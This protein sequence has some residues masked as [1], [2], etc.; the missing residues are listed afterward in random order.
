ML[1]SELPPSMFYCGEQKLYV[2]GIEEDKLTVVLEWT[3]LVHSLI[4]Q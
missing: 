3:G 2:I 1:E 4:E